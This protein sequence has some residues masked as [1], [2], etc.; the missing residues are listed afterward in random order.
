MTTK[1]ILEIALDNDAFQPDWK[2]GVVCML[3]NIQR[4]ITDCVEELTLYDQNG[5]KV[6]FYRVTTE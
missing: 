4:Q 3:R 5:N 6:G 2:G 1:F